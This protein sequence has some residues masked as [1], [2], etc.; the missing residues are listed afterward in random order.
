[1]IIVKGIIIAVVLLTYLT[2]C[3]TTF[4]E[5]KWGRAFDCFFEFHFRSQEPA[6]YWLF[7]V[8]HLLA[9]LIFMAGIAIFGIHYIMG[10]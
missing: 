4:L 1:M 5:I 10:Y 7:I 3:V 9:L 2:M 6:L 8:S